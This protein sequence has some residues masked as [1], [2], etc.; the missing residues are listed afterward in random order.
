MDNLIDF[1]RVYFSTHPVS[2]L[3][4]PDKYNVTD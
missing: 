4:N 1:E 3:F 2:A